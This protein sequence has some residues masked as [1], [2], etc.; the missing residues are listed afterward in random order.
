MARTYRM[1]KRRRQP[2][3]YETN[4]TLTGTL[5]GEEVTVEDVA[6]TV[7]YEFEGGERAIMYGD[8]ACPGS[9]P[10]VTI[11]TVTVVSTGEDVTDQA[12]L[13]TLRDDIIEEIGASDAADDDD[14]KFDEMRDRRLMGED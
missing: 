13:D 1:P 2:D 11:G 3:T 4:I 14:R 9:D 5:Y 6:V 7:T 12:D 8:N 10:E